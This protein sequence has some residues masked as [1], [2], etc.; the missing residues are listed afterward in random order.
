M[1]D[2]A[3]ATAEE[4]KKPEVTTDAGAQD[5]KRRQEEEAENEAAQQ[6]RREQEAIQKAHAKSEEDKKKREQQETAEQTAQRMKRLEVQR[7]KADEFIRNR[8][9]N[10]EQTKKKNRIEYKFSG[11]DGAEHTVFESQIKKGNESTSFFGYYGKKVDKEASLAAVLKA[12]DAGLES[13]DVHGTEEQKEYLARLAHE[14]GLKVANYDMSKLGIDQDAD[15]EKKNEAGLTGKPASKFGNDEKPDA[16]AKAADGPD[17]PDPKTP[18]GGELMKLSGETAPG[19]QQDHA[20]Q[21]PNERLL[22]DLEDGKIKMTRNADGSVTIEA[23][24][25]GGK[26]SA[27]GF[28]D[29]EIVDAEFEEI[30]TDKA[31]PDG[32]KP[33]LLEGPSTSF[34]PQLLESKEPKQLGDGRIT[35]PGHM[36]PAP[37]EDQPAAE[38]KSEAKKDDAAKPKKSKPQTKGTRYTG[39]G[40]DQHNAAH[41]TP[42]GKNG[43]DAF[44]SNKHNTFNRHRN[45]THRPGGH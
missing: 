19:L 42:R 43:H 5:K 30:K 3:V 1:T 10:S 27:F 8:M 24:S 37:Q 12:A 9:K 36:L 39:R 6:R 40:Q 23:A 44:K 14:H 31:L 29:G 28:T 26:K 25:A 15:A 32:S 13:V 17:K 45:S 7:E 38:Q 35:D 20:G 34:A 11:A 21:N 16:D 18:G 4:E 33:K 22:Q 2:S 41:K